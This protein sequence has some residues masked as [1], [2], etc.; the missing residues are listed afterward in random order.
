MKK[1]TSVIHIDTNTV[2]NE[3]IYDDFHGNF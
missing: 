2:V 1:Y 3:Q